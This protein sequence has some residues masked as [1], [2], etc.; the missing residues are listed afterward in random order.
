MFI[1]FEGLDCSGKT[2]QATL[3]VSRLQKLGKG[4]LLLREPG[5]TEISERIRSILLDNRHGEMSRKAELLL[6]SAA[7]TQ[8]VTQVI[9]PALQRGTIVICDRFH[10]ST[11]AYQ[12]YG[13]GLNLDEVRMVNA[14]AT[15]GTIPGLTLFIDIELDEIVRRRTRAQQS[16]DRMES[17]GRQFYENVRRGFLTLA[18]LEPQRFVIVNGMEKVE[19]IHA[20]I[21]TIIQQRLSL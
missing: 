19:D 21:W 13:R 2:T 7:R 18:G 4:V 16:T 3:L 17:S 12:G 9:R 14:I 20:R 5:G 8:L 11:S 1:S 10:D 6:F 15:D